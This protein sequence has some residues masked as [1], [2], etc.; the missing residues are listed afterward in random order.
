MKR[1]SSLTQSLMC[2]I[3]FEKVKMQRR[4]NFQQLHN[5][6]GNRNGITIPSLDS[7]ACPMVY[8][9]FTFD[10]NLKKKLIDKK[11]FVAT[12]WPN[13]FQ[14]CEPVDVEYQL[15]NQIIAIPIDQRYGKEEMDRIIEQ[16]CE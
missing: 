11:I 16:I 12:Y 14:W 3:N 15:A 7:F 6:L 10:S 5:E 2:N 13:V 4:V 8:P 1:M 9:Y